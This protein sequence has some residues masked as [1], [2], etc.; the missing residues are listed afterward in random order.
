MTFT[1]KHSVKQALIK[2]VCRLCGEPLEDCPVK[3][4][5]VRQPKPSVGD[6]G[7]SSHKVCFSEY[8]QHLS[9]DYAERPDA[10]P[11]TRQ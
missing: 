6:A 7:E 8:H 9:R 10:G 3:E 5:T 11:W 2:S 4:K 1:P